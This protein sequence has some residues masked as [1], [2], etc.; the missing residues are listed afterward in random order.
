MTTPTTTIRLPPDLRQRLQQYARA[1][2]K[3]NTEVIVQALRVFFE[4]EDL[5]SR[6]SR[7]QRELE[8]LAEIDRTD[9][10]LA[11]FHDEP[12]ADPFGRE[13]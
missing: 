6:R 10:E 11:G 5:D 3:T 2:N 8:R 1:G 12:E 4:Q 9:P 7:I 13:Q